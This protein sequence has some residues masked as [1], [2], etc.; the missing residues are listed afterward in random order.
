MAGHI[1][2]LTFVLSFLLAACA[3]TSSLDSEESVQQVIAAEIAFSDYSAKHGF[4]AAF[5]KFLADEAV[6]FPPGTAPI[7]DRAA[8]VEYQKAAEGMLITWKP[9][10]AQATHD[11][12]YTWGKYEIRPEGQPDAD[13]LA[14][15]NYVTIWVRDAQGEWKAV[16]DIGNQ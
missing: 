15:G 10:D 6:I 4:S 14:S 1:H 7:E 9:S 5:D 16:L 2:K 12:G 3:S 13:V 11:M 8:I